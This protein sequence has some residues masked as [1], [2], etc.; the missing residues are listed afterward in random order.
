[1]ISALSATVDGAF[2]LFAING[3]LNDDQ[4]VQENHSCSE[5]LFTISAFSGHKTQLIGR[6]PKG[7]IRNEIDPNWYTDSRSRIKFEPPK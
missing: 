3:N 7:C 2:F 1:M 4:E 6:L 5:Q